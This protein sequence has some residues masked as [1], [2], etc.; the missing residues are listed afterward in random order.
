M[1]IN[2]KDLQQSVDELDEI[3]EECYEQGILMGRSVDS[4]TAYPEPSQVT[5]AACMQAIMQW[6]TKAL[7]AA[8]VQTRLDENDIWLSHSRSRRLNDNEPAIRT[9][10][11]KERIKELQAMLG[12]QK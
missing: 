4:T 7:Q 1:T 6:H 5:K 8:E 2:P 3:V 12:E 9:V 11:F 10:D